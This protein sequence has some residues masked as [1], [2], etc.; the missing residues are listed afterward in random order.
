MFGGSFDAGFG[1]LQQLAHWLETFCAVLAWF[2]SKQVLSLFS[3][4][5]SIFFSLFW[6]LSLLLSLSMFRKENSK[7]DV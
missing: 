3:V 5:S 7:I 2:A 4:F 1:A 6:S